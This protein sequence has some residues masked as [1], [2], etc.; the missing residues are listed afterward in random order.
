MDD[1]D[2]IRIFMG[3]FLVM[4][5]TLVLWMTMESGAFDEFAKCLTEPS[6]STQQP[7]A[8]KDFHAIITDAQVEEREKSSPVYYLFLK[9]DSG[10]VKKVQCSADCYGTVQKLF[11]TEEN[12][13]VVSR[14][15][16]GTY[17]WD[18][19]PLTVVN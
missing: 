3:V 13:I 1:K 19:F 7:A 9:D 10:T 18:E 11:K 6:Y 16:S 14:E 4:I 8:P 5:M 15:K 17:H 12:S 2:I